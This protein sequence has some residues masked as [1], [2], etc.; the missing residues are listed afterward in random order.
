[1][2]IF[3]CRHAQVYNPKKIVYRRLP[4]YYLSK[5]G[6]AEA[7][8]M[9]LFLKKYKIKEIFTS[10]M[11]RCVQ[12]AGI[13]KKTID[14][15]AIKIYQKDYLNEWDEGEKTTTVA[16][17]MRH[18]LKDKKDNRVYISHQHPIRVFLNEI[19]SQPPQ[20]LEQ[21]D[22]PAGAIYE[23]AF[24]GKKALP[25]LLFIPKET[26][27][28]LIPKTKF[29]KSLFVIGAAAV[30]FFVVTALEKFAPYADKFFQENISWTT[31]LKIASI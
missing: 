21:W 15:P 7:E 6:E 27:K 1:M 4:G 30:A 25:K 29:S 31:A 8:E 16:K 17:R 18:I 3:I 5:Q 22:C 20:E 13:I 23:I 10:P 28:P 26:D 19:T 12:T 2:N 24:D 14:N 11:E 9:G